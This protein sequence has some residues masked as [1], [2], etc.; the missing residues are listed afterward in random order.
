MIGVMNEERP[1][2]LV[3]MENGSIAEARTRSFLMDRFWILERSVDIDGADFLIQRRLTARTLLDQDPPR[4]GIIQVKFFND[5]NTTQQIHQSYV[6][7]VDG[8]S[9]SEFFLI[10]HT[11]FENNTKA[12]FLTAEEIK[13][14]FDL[15]SFGDSRIQK[16]KLPGRKIMTPL[17]K[18]EIVNAKLV[19]DR[20]ERALQR[21]DFQ[22]NRKFLNWAIPSMRIDENQIDE[23]YCVP[24]DNS[25]CNIPES[26]K[27]LKE[28]AFHEH[29]DIEC[30]MLRPLQK[31]VESTDP[32]QALA[33]AEYYDKEHGRGALSRKELFDEDF[34]SAVIAHKKIYT[35]LHQ[36]GLLDRFLSLRE[37]FVEIVSSEVAP[38]M[39][40]APN[41]VHVIDVQYEAVSFELIRFQSNF[42]DFQELGIKTDLFFSENTIPPRGILSSASGHIKVY[43]RPGGYSYGDS[44]GKK[45]VEAEITDWK[46]T[47][48]EY[49]PSQI[50][51][52]EIFRLRF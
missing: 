48:R 38:R 14:E 13:Q 31:I 33:L 19:L 42:Q 10:C 4:L 16:Y 27:E 29:L 9:R 51:M 22:G 28:K 7:D 3:I 41:V 44:W 23:S 20:I 49:A 26:F 37:E 36:S 43:W 2:W 5:V 11:G 24:I 21:A 45:D 46:E 39:K 18:F 50:L 17:S 30:E 40:L 6:V 34:R 1:T 15:G 12:F 8:N 25:W 35:Q 47:L 52:D 32:E